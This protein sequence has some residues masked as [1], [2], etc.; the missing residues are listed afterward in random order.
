MLKSSLCDASHAC[1]LLSGTI[2]DKN[3]ER[4][5]APHNN[6]K[7]NDDWKFSSIFWLHKW[8]E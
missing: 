1:I 8:N 5:A 7:K 2:T 6:E 3:T 4:A